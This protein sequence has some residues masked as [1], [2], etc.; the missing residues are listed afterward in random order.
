MRRSV[1]NINKHLRGTKELDLFECARVD[2]NVPIEEAIKSLT[3]LKGEGKFSHIGMSES[4]SKTL[5]KAHA[6]STQVDQV[7]QSLIPRCYRS[8]PSRPWKSNSALGHMRTK[9]RKVREYD[10]TAFGALTVLGPSR[11]HCEGARHCSSRILATWARFF[12]WA[13]KIQG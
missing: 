6:V 12:N 8:T 1:D 11:C 10:W 7:L 2:P 3:K 4:S 13:D 5:R 9:P